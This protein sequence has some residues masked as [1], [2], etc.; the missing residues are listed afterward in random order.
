MGEACGTYESMHVFFLR[1]L[2]DRDY[3]EDLG[4]DA[5]TILKWDLRKLVGKVWAGLI[6]RRIRTW[7]AF[8]KAVMNM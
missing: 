5:S 8:V 4:V 1:I 6:W 7:W 2:R 3:F